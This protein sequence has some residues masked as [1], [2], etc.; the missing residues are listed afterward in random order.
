[1]LAGR[2]HGVAAERPAAVIIY[3]AWAIGSAVERLVHTEEVTG[4]NPV[5]PTMETPATIDLG[6]HMPRDGTE[7]SRRL[8]VALKDTGFEPARVEASLRGTLI[9]SLILDLS[10]TDIHPDVAA[11]AEDDVGVREIAG[12]EPGTVRE[13]YVRAAPLRLYGC[14]ID[15]DVRIRNLQIE[16]LTYEDGSIGLTEATDAPAGALVA[17]RAR[18][19]IAGVE[20]ALTQLATHVPG[21]RFDRP[22]IYASERGAGAFRI[23]GYVRVRFRFL[24]AQLGGEIRGR[25]CER[26]IE[27]SRISLK[28]SNPLLRM[29]SSKILRDVPRRIAFSEFLPEGM[30]FHNLR[31]RITDYLQI[32]GTVR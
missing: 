24:S 22:R 9:E 10:G 27:I 26:G 8:A 2:G 32:E 14:V 7:F 11:P 19:P 21:V 15:F 1:M 29:F 25:L 6:F 30:K 18:A 31:L 4:S 17:F 5:S 3:L 12:R 20:T 23:G 28:R 16:W 13:L